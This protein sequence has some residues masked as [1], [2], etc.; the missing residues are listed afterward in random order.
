MDKIHFCNHCGAALETKM[1]F[2]A[3]CGQPVVPEPIGSDDNSDV[4]AFPP[5]GQEQPSH[6]RPWL[7]IITVV[8][9][10]ISMTGFGLAVVANAPQWQSWLNNL[11]PMATSPVLLSLSEEEAIERVASLPEVAAWMVQVQTQAPN[12][13]A[14]F[15]IAET[16]PQHY[17]VHVYESVNNAGEPSHT[18][19]Y[20]WY[21]VNRQSGIVMR[22]PL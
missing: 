16:T 4:S 19:T 10:V 9:F 7:K 15:A 18:A 6:K 17:L 22:R 12:N 14:S 21:S 13:R 2:C 20:G 3:A 5:Q 11:E 8:V 1:R